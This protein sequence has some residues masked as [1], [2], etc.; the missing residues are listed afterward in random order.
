[1][2]LFSPWSFQGDRLAPPTPP[3]YFPNGSSL[4]VDAVLFTVW[5]TDGLVSCLLTFSI[6]FNDFKRK[7]F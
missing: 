2:I 1:M 3:V 6:S 7:S 4:G 5:K